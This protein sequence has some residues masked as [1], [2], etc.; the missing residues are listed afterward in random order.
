LNK[1]FHHGGAL[2][3]KRVTLYCPFLIRRNKPVST[4]PGPISSMLI[5]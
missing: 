4:L 2:L 1:F 3:G 5:S